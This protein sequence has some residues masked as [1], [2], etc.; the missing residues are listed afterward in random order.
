MSFAVGA[1]QNFCCS[2]R[3]VVPKYYQAIYFAA[4]AG[5]D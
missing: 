3:S 5:E 1:V 4:S 2:A